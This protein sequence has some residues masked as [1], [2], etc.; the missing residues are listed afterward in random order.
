[1]IPGG[2]WLTVAKRAVGRAYAPE[3]GGASS[4][5]PH[6]SSQSLTRRSRTNAVVRE[7]TDRIAG[8]SELALERIDGLGE[9]DL[10]SQDILIEVVRE[11]EKQQWMLRA[12]LGE[13]V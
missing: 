11:L 7:L 6:S 4:Q 1:M 13:H 8:P 2:T 12:Q 10:A 3:R 9:V 5:A